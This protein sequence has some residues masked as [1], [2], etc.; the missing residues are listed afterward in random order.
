[1]AQSRERERFVAKTLTA[2]LVEPVG[3]QHLD[4][5]LTA[6]PGVLCKE[7]GSHAT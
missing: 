7:N 3:R 4:G 5:H 1:M 2:L 6:Q